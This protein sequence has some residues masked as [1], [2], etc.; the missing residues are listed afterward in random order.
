MEEF[1]WC[2]ILEYLEAARD[3]AQNVMM[4]D[5]DDQQAKDEYEELEALVE[6]FKR[7]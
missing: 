4:H 1:Q 6:D 3:E 5:E 7:A 2:E